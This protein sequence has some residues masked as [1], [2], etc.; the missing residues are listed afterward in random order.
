M[1]STC[2]F[3]CHQTCEPNILK[4]NGKLIL[5]QIGRSGPRGLIL[6]MY[7]INTL[8]LILSKMYLIMSKHRKTLILLKKLVFISNLNVFISMLVICFF[9]S[10]LMALILH[11]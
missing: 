6:M 2:P 3:I 1:L 10:S 5:M 7:E 8:L 11:S 4:A 9:Y